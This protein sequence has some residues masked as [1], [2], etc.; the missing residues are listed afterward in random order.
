M[1]KKTLDLLIAAYAAATGKTFEEAR[2]HCLILALRERFAQQQYALLFFGAGA[3]ICKAE[4]T[5]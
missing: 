4:E 1:K 2:R 3:S 5:T